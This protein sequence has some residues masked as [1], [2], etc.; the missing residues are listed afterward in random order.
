[1]KVKRHIFVLILMLCGLSI[2]PNEIL[3]KAEQAYDA[4]NYKQA[5]ELYKQLIDDGK[6]AYQ[7][8]FNLGNAYYRNKDL[9]YAIY[10]YEMARKLNPNDQDIS[11]NLSIATS[12]TIDKIDAK[13]NFFISA[14]K[15]NVVNLFTTN[16]WAW[17]SIASIFLACALF[18]LF[19][20]SASVL[21]KRIS[22]VLSFLFLGVFILVY[23]SG[24]TALNS[25]HENK[26]AIILKKEVKV[27]NEPTPSAVLKFMLHEG[28][29]V[30]IVE[31][32]GEWVLIKLDNG[33]EGWLSQAEVG[34]I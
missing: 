25:K 4:K 29:K 7:L 10:Y 27:T 31:A 33:N 22:F 3:K 32:K 15:S 24:N 11:I 18:F 34:T 21:I 13:E 16:Q 20:A 26:F 17:F 6:R 1:M 9:G 30:K 2:K 5:I 28:T 19:I 14:V 23:V 8:Y 12:K